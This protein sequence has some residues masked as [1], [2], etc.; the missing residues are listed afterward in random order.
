MA[1]TV[2]E[3]MN[4]ELFSVRPTDSSEEALG[5][6]LAL[7][8]TGAPVV[9]ESGMPVGM[10]SFRDLLARDTHPLVE[11]RMT[12]PALTVNEDASIEEAARRLSDGGIHRLAAVDDQGHVV[13]V[14]SSLDVIRGLVGLPASH[15][16]TFPHYDTALGISWTD[17]TPLEVERLGAAPDGPGVFAL[18]RGGRGMSESVVWAEAARNVRTRL[19][20][21]VSLPQE[22]PVLELILR[23][24]Q[25]LRFRAAA[26]ADAPARMKALQTLLAEAHKKLEAVTA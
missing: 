10:V 15:P 21:V 2:R 16:A 22:A 17:D 20:D 18:V 7:G 1:K 9:D 23:E 8:I 26:I 25:H 19:Y 24:R 5:Y 13:G 11:S 4:R 6:I 12:R 3:I 14:V